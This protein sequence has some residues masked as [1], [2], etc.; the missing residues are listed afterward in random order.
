MRNQRPLIADHLAVCKV[1]FGG[2][3]IT[4]IQRVASV[5]LFGD[6]RKD[7]LDEILDR[8]MMVF[9]RTAHGPF[10]FDEKRVMAVLEF[11]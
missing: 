6:Y 4:P 7:V 5:D 8:A 9:G 11:E 2:Q 10:A 1:S 3:W